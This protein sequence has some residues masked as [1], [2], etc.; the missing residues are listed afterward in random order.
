MNLI[1]QQLKKINWVLIIFLLLASVIRLWSLGNIPAHPTPDEAALGYNAYSII[2]T[3]R[4]E[5]G[6]RL[7]LIFKSFGDYKP[8]LYVY[9][10]IPSI[11][12]LGLN[13]FA[14]RLPSALVGILIVFL[15]YKIINLLFYEEFHIFKKILTMGHLGAFVAALNPWL[16]YFSR[17]AWEANVSLALTL[18]GIYYF[19]TSLNNKPVSLIFATTFFALAPLTYQGGKLSSLI[20]L[21]LLV[22]VYWK[23]FVS[24][25]KKYLV[26]SF[27]VGLLI[28]L[29]IILSIFSTKVGRLNILS[30][31]SYPRPVEQLQK[32]LDQGKEEVGS[33]SY[34]IFHS[35]SVNFFRAILGRLFNHFSGRYLFFDGDWQNPKY[36][37]PN[38]GV[39]L[40]GDILI[41][42]IGFWFF[43]KY[44]F[45][46]EKLFIFLWLLFAP[47]PAILSRDQVQS[48]RAL[49]TS[50]PLVIFLTFGLYAIV[51]SIKNIKQRISQFLFVV[52]IL[53]VYF[54]GLTYFLDSYFVHLPKHD[55]KDRYYGYK[56]VVEVLRPIEKD[57]K[58]IIFQQSYDQPYIYFL[59]FDKY[60]PE[61]Y[62]K[63]A[64]LLDSE[65]GNVG[66]VEKLD[67]IQFKFLSWPVSEEKGALV[68]VDGIT[69]PRE[70]IGDNFKL[71]SHIGYPDGKNT[72]FNIVEVE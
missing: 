39:L 33:L 58:T 3:G 40:I 55:A 20:V 71:I 29:P 22:G 37:A 46:R 6:Q 31:F 43:F 41:L 49:N 25:G 64:K 56:Q 30:I 17:G 38:S 32:L 19:V 63:Q 42:S 54:L 21:L 61:K 48:V 60:D 51:S 44:K 23:R 9:L 27:V 18:L 62:Q 59:F 5:Y 16:I 8:G 2:K 26:F 24:V 35:E 65:Y 69:A 4:D 13:E 57:Y 47:L 14:V 15:V 72:A 10:T 45:S 53:S 36:S 67:N 1:V 28:S 34:Y 7:P 52:V 50:V 11:L 66:L 12:I 68:V 70:M